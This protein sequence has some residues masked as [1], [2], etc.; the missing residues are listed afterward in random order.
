M[1]REK[2]R[3][4]QEIMSCLKHGSNEDVARLISSMRENGDTSGSDSE[5]VDWQGVPD[6]VAQDQTRLEQASQILVFYPPICRPL[7]KAQALT[8]L[9][10]LKSLVL[11]TFLR[12]LLSD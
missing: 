12:K 2:I 10:L 1:L 5:K 11:K 4:L 6:Q 9:S 8:S 7:R 3:G